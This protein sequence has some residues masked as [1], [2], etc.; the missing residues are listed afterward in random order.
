LN[1]FADLDVSARSRIDWRPPHFLDLST[2]DTLIVDTET[3]GLKWWDGHRVIGAAVSLLDGT[4]F[5][6]PWGHEGGGNVDEDAAKRWLRDQLKGKNIIGQNMKFDNH[7]LRVSGVDLEALGCTLY[8][9]MHLA[10][11]LDDHRKDF[12]LDTL[13][14][15]ILGIEGKLETTAFTN[16]LIDKSRMASY[17]AGEIAAYAE[18]DAHLTARLWTHM[19]PLAAEQELGGVIDLESRLIYPVCYMERN[20]PRIDVEKLERW[21][22]KSEGEFSAMVR[23]LHQETGVRM[24]SPDAQKPWKKLF[25]YLKLDYPIVEEYVKGKIVKKVSFAEPVLKSIKHP[26]VQLGRDIKA[27]NSL[28]NKFMKSYI[29]GMDDDG[30]LRSAFHPLRSDEG[31]TISGRFSSSGYHFPATMSRPAERIGC[32]LQQVYKPS[33]QRKRFGQDYEYI[34]RELFIPEKGETWFSADAKQIEYRIF[35][36]Y[37]NSKNLIGRYDADPETDYHDIVM[38]MLSPFKEIERDSV[39]TLNF[40]KIY[41]AGREKLADMLG[42]PIHESNLFVNLY[43][44]EIPEAKELMNLVMKV[45]R[46]RG[47]VKTI[48]GRRSRFPKAQRLHKALNSIVQGTAADIMKEKIVETYEHKD[49]FGITM[50]MTVHD[51]L[52]GDAP[53]A[54]QAER[55][56]LLLNEQSF[57]L[58]VPILWDMKT[59]PNWA[60][61]A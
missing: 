44:R 54:E 19:R 22:R 43:E 14:K 35:A 42:M 1:L 41:G 40:A 32:N 11:L 59:G 37:S 3:T 13:A 15:E 6:V 47:W 58:K 53:D 50:R 26:M 9:T 36:H 12:H 17:H 20:P 49:K 45:A 27:L 2:E 38:D 4:S 60:E 56:R 34:I 55:L 33:K 39:K 18:R 29:L 51:E 23:S 31:G 28:R 46:Q 16:Q 30:R 7:I 25:D 8:D 61:C 10:A 5:Y 57:D 24:D 48:L 21:Y 52:D